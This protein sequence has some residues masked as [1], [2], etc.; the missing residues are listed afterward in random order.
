MAKELKQPEPALDQENQEAQGPPQ[1]YRM[2][3]T[4]ALV[5]LVLFQMIVLIL[6]LPPKPPPSPPGGHRVITE[7]GDGS[8]SGTSPSPPR[9]GPIERVVERPINDAPFRIGFTENDMNIT[10]SL[11]IHVTIREKEAKAFDRRYEQC[12]QQI[13]ARVTRVISASTPADR[14]EVGH[15]AIQEKLKREINDVLQTP[16]VL[17]VLISEPN[18]QAT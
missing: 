9:V 3:V 18:I 7:G 1:S 17:E 4:L 12:V 16:W 15:T 10:F 8:W 13:I 11:R 14:N 2:Q 6:L 5:G